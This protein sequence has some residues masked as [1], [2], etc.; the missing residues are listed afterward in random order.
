M[1][2]PAVKKAKRKPTGA[3]AMGAGP[4]R[5]KGVPNKVPKAIKEAALAALNSGEGA[6]A[7]FEQRKAESPDA[8]MGF[9]KGV[10]PMDVRLGNPDG[11]A[12]DVTIN[13]KKPK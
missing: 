7:F 11:S 5:P 8:F 9:L 4:G 12:L 13:L 2:K 1:N 3:A 10:L 6:E